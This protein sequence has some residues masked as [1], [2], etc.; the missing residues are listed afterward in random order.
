MAAVRHKGVYSTGSGQDPDRCAL[1]FLIQR[2]QLGQEVGPAAGRRVFP[3]W[4]RT[5]RRAGLKPGQLALELGNTP[6][7]IGQLMPQAAD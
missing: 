4:R 5:V 3:G 6:V 2:V 1:F 7:L